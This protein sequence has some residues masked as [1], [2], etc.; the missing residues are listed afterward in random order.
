MNARLGKGSS[1]MLS[2]DATTATQKALLA[3]SANS[4]GNANSV[5]VNYQFLYNSFAT[6]TFL[7]AEFRERV[8]NI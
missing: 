5:R 2:L 3:T 7:H 8:C 6:V 4:N 1:Q